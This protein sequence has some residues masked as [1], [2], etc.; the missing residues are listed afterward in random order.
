MTTEHLDF[1][2]VPS[3]QHDAMNQSHDE[4]IDYASIPIRNIHKRGRSAAHYYNNL[5]GSDRN[6]AL[7]H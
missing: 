6:T 7:M 4:I 3:L 5:K 2:S 1:I